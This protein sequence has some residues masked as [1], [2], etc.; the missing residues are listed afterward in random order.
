MFELPIR[1][2]DFQSQL[3]SGTFSAQQALQWQK[4]RLIELGSHLNCLVSECESNEKSQIGPLSGVALAHKDIFDLPGRAPGLGIDCGRFDPL[5][6]RAPVLEQLA[7]AG[8]TQ[9]A[10]L[11]MA[12]QA[13][14]AT[15][16]NPH[17]PRVLNPIEP[18]MA[19]GGSSSGCAVA[20]AA[21]LTY[22]SLGTDTAGSVRIPAATCGVLGLKTTLGLIN[23][24]GT[25]PLA[26]SLDSVGLLARHAEDVLLALNVLAPELMPAQKTK[27][28]RL[29][30]WLPKDMLDSQIYKALIDWLFKFQ[31][32][33]LDLQE[34]FHKL[35][36]HAQRVLYF[37]TAQ[38]HR[39]ALL[40]GQVDSAVETLGYLGL[41]MPEDWYHQS[42]NARGEFLSQFVASIFSSYDILILPS[43][44]RPV[45]DWDKVYIGETHFDKYELLSLHHFMSFINY[46]G[47]PAL[48]LPITSDL[49]G[50]PICVQLVARPYA[51]HLLLKF[52]SDCSNISFSSL[53]IH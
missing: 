45:P 49:N 20:V 23:T 10:T 30:A 36:L 12:P 8:A 21:G 7:K 29:C 27:A 53:E 4:K 16:Q 35:S 17:F 50:R 5:R 33:A 38:T 52:A 9:F 18:Q 24:S 34:Q 40:S 28:L 39:A 31:Y 47:L 51:E 3:R 6:R 1:L 13:C 42:M 14:G 26:P 46:L 25:A 22:F 11:V 44:A 37:E 32:D 41:A 2:S 19:V 15:G 48:N 43:L